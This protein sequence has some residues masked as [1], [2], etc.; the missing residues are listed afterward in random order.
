MNLN[1]WTGHFV[2]E[3]KKL[4]ELEDV[5]TDQQMGARAISLMIDRVTAS[6]LG[7]APTTI[8]NTL[9]DA[10]GQREINTLY[11]QTNQYH[12][13]LEADP[14]VA[15][16][17][18]PA[19]QSVYPI[20]RIVRSKRSRRGDIILLV[21]IGICRLERAD[22]IRQIHAVFRGA[23]GPGIAQGVITSASGNSS[24]NGGTFAGTTPNASYLGRQRQCHPAECLHQGIA[25]HRS[26]VDQPSGPVPF[27]DGLV[28]PGAERFAWHGHYRHRQGSGE[29]P[30]PGQSAGG[31]PGNRGFLQEL[32]LQ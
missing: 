22:Y 24:Q 25:D 27:R 18:V 4:P 6:R 11:T 32:A 26:A 21:C 30:L 13:I 29:S 12:V 7:I 3:L 1:Q 8:D 19:Q 5:A 2:A 28:Q 31:L 10:F 15:T 23:D 9:Y 16:R 17:S 20:Q 14:A